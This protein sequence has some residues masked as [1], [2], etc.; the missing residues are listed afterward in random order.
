MADIK[1]KPDQR[2]RCKCHSACDATLVIVKLM[3]ERISGRD[4]YEVYHDDHFLRDKH[5]V[6]VDMIEALEAVA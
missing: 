6:T 2:V 1:F 5:L 4:V 3:D